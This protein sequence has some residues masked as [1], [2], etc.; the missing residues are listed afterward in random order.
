ML[1]GGLASGPG[2]SCRVSCELSNALSG[3]QHRSTK[4][5]NLSH[6]F[7]LLQRIH[8]RLRMPLSGNRRIDLKFYAP[9]GRGNHLQFG[10]LCALSIVE[11]MRGGILGAI[12]VSSFWS[13]SVARL[14]M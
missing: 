1:H 8:C 5:P 2:G 9:F 11:L 4:F 7:D 13:S 14:D 6:P 12:C 3:M 10:K